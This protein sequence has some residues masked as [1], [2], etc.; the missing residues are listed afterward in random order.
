MP[1]PHRFAHAG[2]GQSG[3]AMCARAT[4]RVARCEGEG[5]CSQRA[6]RAAARARGTRAHRGGAAISARA[7]HCARSGACG[8]AVGVLRARTEGRD[9]T[10]DRARGGR[11]AA[12]HRTVGHGSHRP[13][14]SRP[15]WRTPMR[16][17]MWKFPSEVPVYFRPRAVGQ[18][19][20][21]LP[22]VCRKA[23]KAH[24]HGEGAAGM[25]ASARC[26]TS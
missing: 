19:Q 12:L 23:A 20:P 7:Q 14:P 2:V 25:S 10:W 4:R 26:P 17:P 8:D 18:R 9:A 15:L 16:S 21:P 11:A 24:A 13:A 6:S 1:C 5:A 22:A 3:R